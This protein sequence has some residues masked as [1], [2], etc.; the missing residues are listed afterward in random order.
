[1]KKILFTGFMASILMASGAYAVDASSLTTKGYVDTGLKW[2]KGAADTA[3]AAAS[4][5]Q[6]SAN[7]AQSY[8][9]GVNTVVVGHTAKLA[10]IDTT[11]V[12]AIDDAADAALNYIDGA[13]G[14][15]GEMTVKDYVDDAIKSTG[16]DV[17][18]LNDA[19]EAEVTRATEAEGTLTT[20]LAAEVTRATAAEGAN[21]TAIGALEDK[22]TCDGTSC[23]LN[24]NGTFVPVDT[25]TLFTEAGMETGSN[26]EPQPEP[27]PGPQEG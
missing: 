18:D 26:Q 8:A 25:A 23:V 19:I 12:D 14:E 10:G 6:T 22:F 7:N 2:A 16:G 1:M 17:S 24:A 11:V 5:A 9:E 21:A 3:Q 4:A 15:I 13:I 20:N 27:E